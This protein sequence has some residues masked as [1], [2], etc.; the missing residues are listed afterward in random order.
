VGK[1]SKVRQVIVGN[2]AAGLSAIKAIREVDQSCPITLISAESCDAYSP[3]LLTYYLSGRISREGLFI[4]D[5]DSYKINKV[6]TIFGNKVIGLD[7]SKQ[8]V[9]LEDGGRVE[10]DNLL[11]AT[12]ASP[13]TLGNGLKNVVSLRTV[14]DTERI[15]ELGGRAKEAVIVGSGLIGLQ[16]G[17]SL[18]KKG[19]RPTFVEWAEQV[20]PENIDTDCAAIVQ[21]EIESQGIPV[22]LGKRVKE[23]RERGEKTIVISDA[24]DEWVADMVIV[25]IGLRPNIQFAKDSGIKVNRGVLVDELMRT[26]ISN[27]FAAGDVA[28]GENLVTGEREVLA[29]WNN[30]TKQ[31]RIAGLNMADYQQRFEGGLKENVTT[32]FGLTI[33]AMGLAR[34]LKN[35]GLEELR[36]TDSKKKVYRKILLSDNKIVGA[37]LLGRTEDAGIIGN[38]IRTRL[39][40]S[41]WKDRLA[42][43]PLNLREILLPLTGIESLTYGFR[44]QKEGGK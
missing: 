31:G 39:D 42:K 40:I 10:Y 27:I 43:I 4:A 32:V 2:S 37:I 20:F 18:C 41:P 16:A 38:L 17:D 7:P 21:Q 24:G 23:V 13:I 8:T 14:E 5:S 29:N 44:S 34:A 30:A 3:V 33:A 11:I 26:N 1:V 9:Y 28:E 12:G 19:V 6:K 35:S 15:L 36:F 25:G 22:F